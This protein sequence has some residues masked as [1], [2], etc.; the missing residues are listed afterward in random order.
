MRFLLIREH[1]G[2]LGRWKGMLAGTGAP[3]VYDLANDPDEKKDLYNT[4]AGAVGTRFVI[5]PMWMLRHWNVEWKK[6]QWG[7]AAD[8]S[9]RFASDLGE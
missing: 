2:R 7:N 4:A 1:A 8:V 6:A 9:N 5:D 3:R